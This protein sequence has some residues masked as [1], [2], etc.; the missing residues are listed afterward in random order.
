MK[1]NFFSPKLIVIIKQ[2][3]VQEYRNLVRKISIIIVAF[4]L[5][6][7][8]FHSQ[9]CGDTCVAPGDLLRSSKAASH[10]TDTPSSVERSVHALAVVSLCLGQICLNVCSFNVASLGFFIPAAEMYHFISVCGRRNVLF[11]L[12]AAKHVGV[13][14]ATDGKCISATCVLVLW[15]WLQT[16][17][18][19]TPFSPQDN[20]SMLI[21]T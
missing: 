8:I 2:T 16:I 12:G 15:G 20:Q 11:N 5:P 19:H 10:N 4:Q 14:N 7:W 3:S 21:C 18:P 6:F 13:R 1:L 9:S 17:Y